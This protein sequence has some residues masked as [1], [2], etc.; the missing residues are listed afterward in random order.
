MTLLRSPHDFTRYA[1]GSRDTKGRWTAGATSTISANCHIQ[2][3]NY[4]AM[5]NS[6]RQMVSSMGLEHVQGFCRVFSDDEL[7]AANKASGLMGDTFTFESN[8]Y[9]IVSVNHYTKLLPHYD[10]IA[11]LVDEKT[12]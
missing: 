8:T 10:C 11:A 12:V 4:G 7:R 6:Q 2:P 5:G 1:A 9:E 3:L